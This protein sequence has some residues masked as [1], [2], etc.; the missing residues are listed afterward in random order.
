MYIMTLLVLHMYNL[1]NRQ[2]IANSGEHL[3]G[4]MREV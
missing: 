1:E 3:G 2:Q 4:I